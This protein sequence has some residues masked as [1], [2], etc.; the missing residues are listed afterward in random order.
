MMVKIIKDGREQFDGL[1]VTIYVNKFNGSFDLEENDDIKLA[2]DDMVEFRVVARVGAAGIT[3]TAKGD[4]K[5]TNTYKVVG[6]EVMSVNSIP[7]VRD[8]YTEPEWI[9]SRNIDVDT[10]EIEYDGTN[11]NSEPVRISRVPMGSD[12]ELD[13]FLNGREEA[14]PEVV[15]AVRAAPSKSS[16]DEELQ[17]FLYGPNR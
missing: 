3:E 16:S 12:P 14:N 17:S 4:I 1:P 2:F 8:E 5:R 15:T 11:M 7:T 9:P 13:S 6:A 10:G